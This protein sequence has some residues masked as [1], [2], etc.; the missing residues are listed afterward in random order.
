MTESIVSQPFSRRNLFRG[1]LILGAGLSLGGV[2][3]CATPTGKPGPDTVSLAMNRS[4]VST[5]R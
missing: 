5:L 1:G 4:M 2:T 3:A